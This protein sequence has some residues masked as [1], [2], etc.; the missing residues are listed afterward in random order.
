MSLSFDWIRKL[1]VKA[2]VFAP[3]SYV[4]QRSDGMSWMGPHSHQ[5]LTFTNVEEWI[6]RFDDK[7]SALAAAKASG[8]EKWLE[9]HLDDRVA[10][11]RDGIRIVSND[12]TI[13]LVKVPRK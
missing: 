7:R 11:V 1:L 6:C 2:G 10:L 8:V 5:G 12:G 3:V 13:K 9:E 4:V